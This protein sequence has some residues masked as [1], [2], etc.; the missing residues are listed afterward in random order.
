MAVGLKEQSLGA[1]DLQD[2]LR[3]RAALGLGARDPVTGDISRP[4]YNSKGV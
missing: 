4:N 1:E 2:I 3:V